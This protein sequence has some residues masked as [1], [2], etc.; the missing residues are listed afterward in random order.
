[1]SEQPLETV[2]ALLVLVHKLY[3]RLAE[4]DGMIVRD[5]AMRQVLVDHAR[6]R[7]AEACGKWPQTSLRASR[8]VRDAA[9][10]IARPLCL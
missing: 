4:S 8:V 9:V 7:L 5:R 2:T 10:A 6:R 1:M 3:V